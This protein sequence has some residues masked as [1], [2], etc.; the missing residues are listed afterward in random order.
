MKLLG[1]MRILIV[2]ELCFSVRKPNAGGAF[3]GLP[4]EAVRSLPCAA[5]GT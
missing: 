5:I 1:L 2:V 4:N 3:T